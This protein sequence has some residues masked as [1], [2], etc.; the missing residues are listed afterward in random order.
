MSADAAAVEM[1]RATANLVLAAVSRFFIFTT[2]T[3][4]NAESLFRVLNTCCRP[5]VT[6]MTDCTRAC[7]LARFSFSE[8]NS[9][10][11]PV[12]AVNMPDR[13]L[14]PDMKPCRLASSLESILVWV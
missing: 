7:I 14:M 4:R 1:P 12:A 6:A 2:V 9:D 8:A 3:R 13:P 10:T 5:I 11:A